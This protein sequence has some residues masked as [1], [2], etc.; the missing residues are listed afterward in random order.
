MVKIRELYGKCE[1]MVDAL[2]FATV[3]CSAPLSFLID[4]CNECWA[5]DSQTRWSQ[6]TRCRNIPKGLITQ[7]KKVTKPN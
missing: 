3:Q 1:T 7:V 2:Q 4:L 6:G 5:S